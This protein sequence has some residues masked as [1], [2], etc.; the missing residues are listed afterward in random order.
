MKYIFDDDWKEYD[1]NEEPRWDFSSFDDLIK[2]FEMACNKQYL[3]NGLICS[4]IEPEEIESDYIEPEE[5][6]IDSEI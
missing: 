3:E 4:V 5:I 1:G 6:L 2:M